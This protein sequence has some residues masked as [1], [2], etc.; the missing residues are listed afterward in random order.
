MRSALACWL[1]EGGVKFTDWDQ[2]LTLE[3]PVN[4]LD[5]AK[6]TGH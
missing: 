1:A 3:A 4:P 2:P 6:L 5:Y